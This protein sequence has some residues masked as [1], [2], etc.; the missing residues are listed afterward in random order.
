MN[1]S[2]QEIFLMIHQNHI[3]TIFIHQDIYF[4]KKIC[5]GGSTMKTKVRGFHMHIY[6]GNIGRSQY[7]KYM[8][9]SKSKM[10][11]IPVVNSRPG[12]K[13]HISVSGSLKNG[14]VKC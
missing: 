1:H 11:P 4:F 6:G 14:Y 12:N 7:P 2:L 10:L 13:G 5:K 3:I 8:D 9:G